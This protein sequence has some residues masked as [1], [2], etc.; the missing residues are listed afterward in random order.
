MKAK[1][2][3]FLFLALLLP[4]AVF[5]FLKV[6]GRNE[7]KVPV[8]HG[9][10]DL[11]VPAQCNFEYPTP[12]IIADSLMRNIRMNNNDSVFVLYA[13]PSDET[14]MNRVRTEFEGDPLHVVSTDSLANTIDPT[15]L[16]ECILLM[17]GDS[18]VALVDHRN[19]IR[20]YYIGSDRDEAHRLIVEIKIILRQY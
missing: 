18:S 13:D 9:E 8:R 4:V 5:L 20:G 2:A 12:Y 10:A 7:F 16:R 17:K 11:T 3:F 1:N 14:S 19:R 15:L 6:F